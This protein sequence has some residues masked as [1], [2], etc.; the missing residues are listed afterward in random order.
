MFGVFSNIFFSIMLFSSAQSV[1][2]IVF[3]SIV[4]VFNELCAKKNQSAILS[5]KIIL[6]LKFISKFPQASERLYSNGMYN[7]C[8]HLLRCVKD[9]VHLSSIEVELMQTCLRSAEA[10]YFYWKRKDVLT[11]ASLLQ[12]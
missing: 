10:V 7:G 9:M 11:R 3:H 1:L 2:F 5:T 8:S 12:T 6:L 4:I